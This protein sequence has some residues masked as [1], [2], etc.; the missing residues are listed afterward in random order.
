MKLTLLLVNVPGIKSDEGAVKEAYFFA[1]LV[2]GFPSVVNSASFV[3]DVKQQVPDTLKYGLQWDQAKLTVYPCPQSIEDFFAEREL[4]LKDLVS[5]GITI[6]VN[7]YYDSA[8]GRGYLYPTKVVVNMGSEKESFHVNRGYAANKTVTVT[9]Y[10][11]GGSKNQT[12]SVDA[13]MVESD[14]LR[15]ILYENIRS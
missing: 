3:R 10:I 15:G 1:S 12:F 5:K 13:V 6:D 9:R 14:T 4:N 7:V 2:S 11:I 8:I